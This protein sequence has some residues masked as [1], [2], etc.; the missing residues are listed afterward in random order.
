MRKSMQRKLHPSDLETV[1]LQRKLNL[2]P[3]K[4]AAGS[5]KLADRPWNI[6][7]Q[8]YF[9]DNIG[10][11]AQKPVIPRK[12]LPCR[13]N[14]LSSFPLDTALRRSAPQA[15][16]FHAEQFPRPKP[17][18]PELLHVEQFWARLPPLPEK[19]PQQLPGL[20]RQQP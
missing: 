13:P 15:E 7:Q 8:A 2:R 11:H 4:L 18:T 9:R 12:I 20:L 19:R 1:A 3:K 16:M 17:S 5:R 14:N 10:A 6:T